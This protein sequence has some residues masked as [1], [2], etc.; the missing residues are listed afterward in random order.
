MTAEPSSV[1]TK[2]SA[3]SDFR[4]LGLNEGDM[5]L[6]QS[7]FRNFRTIQGG[8]RAL[9]EALLLAIGNEGTLIMPTFNFDDF[10]EKKL[11]SKKNTKPQTGLLCELFAEWEG[12]ERIYHPLHGFSLVGKNAVELS[13]KIKNRSSFEEASLFGELLRRNSKL[14]LLGVSYREGL[15]FFHYIEEM[16]GVPYRKFINLTGK[17]EELDETVHEITIPYYGRKTMS[18][19]YDFDK[20]IPYVE[21]ENDSIIKKCVIGTGT[22]RLMNARPIYN[23]LAQALRINPNLVLVN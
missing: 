3:A 9:I 4:A 2:E 6:V 7:G 15:T 17:V 18:V 19:H 16:V 13:Q 20:I 8:P 11:Y 5:V 22:V 10:G 12:R 21:G 1:F 23:R 14:M